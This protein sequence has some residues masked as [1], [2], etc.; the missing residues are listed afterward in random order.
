MFLIVFDRF[1]CFVFANCKIGEIYSGN[2][3]G[4][5]GE[6]KRKQSINFT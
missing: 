3:R 2:E 5:V 1:F 4:G 6:E